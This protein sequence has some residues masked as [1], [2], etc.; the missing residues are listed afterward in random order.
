MIEI[1][2]NIF[3]LISGYIPILQ[4]ESDKPDSKVYFLILWLP[5]Y[6]IFVSCKFTKKV[7][8]L[9]FF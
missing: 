5:L 2:V 1:T 4:M 9:H 8:S 7:I 3:I 6:D